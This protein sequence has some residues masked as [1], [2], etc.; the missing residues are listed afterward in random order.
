MRKIEDFL[1]RNSE[2]FYIIAICFGF[3]SLS[4]LDWKTPAIEIINS[5]EIIRYLIAFFF[6]GIRFVSLFYINKK[7]FLYCLVVFAVLLISFIFSKTTYLIQCVVVLLLS[8]GIDYR[9]IVKT[10]L[11]FSLITF[12]FDVLGVVTGNINVFIAEGYRFRCYLGFKHPSYFSINYVTA[13]FSSWYLVYKDKKSFSSILFIASGLFLWLVP[14]TRTSAI[15]LI[16]MPV[17]VVISKVIISIDSSAINRLVGLAPLFMLFVSLILTF[18]INH[19]ILPETVAIRF[20]QA[21]AYYKNYGVH[22]FTSTNIWLDN[23]YMFLLENFGIILT[24]FYL[25]LFS[26]ALIRSINEKN[27][28]ILA[29]SLALLIYSIL[30]NYILNPRYNIS[31]FYLY[32][33]VGDKH[34]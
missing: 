28:H 11:T 6:L 5:F 14:N 19:S 3:F 25:Y 24:F 8:Y 1:F 23:T 17:I 34:E 9:K 32:T 31:L 16:M 22:I 2:L 26:K 12:L 7:H 33:M 20:S 21:L 18:Y 10:V 4:W 29:I 13:L 30:D 27:Y 15:I